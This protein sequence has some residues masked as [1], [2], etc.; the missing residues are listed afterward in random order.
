MSQFESAWPATRTVGRVAGAVLFC[1]AL[2]DILTRAPDPAAAVERQ[3]D[4]IA[5]LLAAVVT[6]P[7]FIIDRF[8][9]GVALLCYG[10]VVLSA[11]LGYTV[12]VTSLVVLGYGRAWCG[13]DVAS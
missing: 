3:G 10:A 8:P 11:A 6:V 7:L 9:R 1:F 4:A 13:G 5:V 12:A 2:A